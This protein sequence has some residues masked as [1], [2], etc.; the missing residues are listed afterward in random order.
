MLQRAPNE[1]ARSIRL[2]GS[3]SV[4][5]RTICCIERDATFIWDSRSPIERYNTNLPESF[6]RGN[7]LS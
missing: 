7:E 5:I 1:T 3:N 2:A 4:K 6:S